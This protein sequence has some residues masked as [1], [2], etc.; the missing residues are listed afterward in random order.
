MWSE[1][2]LASAFHG[3]SNYNLAPD[4]K[5]IVAFMP[6]E[7]PEGQQSQRDMILLENFFDELRRKAPAGK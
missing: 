4:G 6:A 1:K 7:S 3:G 2:R 5:R